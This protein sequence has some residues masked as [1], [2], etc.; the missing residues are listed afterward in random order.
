M[1]LIGRAAW[2]PANQKR[3]S[4]LDSHQYGI[5]SARFFTQGY[6]RWLREM[7]AVFSV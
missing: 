1:P 6:Q 4:D 7:W 5:S 3:Y 2:A